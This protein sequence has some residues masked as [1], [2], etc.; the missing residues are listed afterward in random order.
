LNPSFFSTLSSW[1]FTGSANR[2]NAAFIGQEKGKTAR[3]GSAENTAQAPVKALL[4][5]FI[6]GGDR[7]R[8]I[9]ERQDSD[10]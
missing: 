7:S 2:I 4:R 5:V 1:S 9:A 8:K 6:G 10:Q 3:F